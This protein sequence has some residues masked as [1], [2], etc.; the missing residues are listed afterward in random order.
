MLFLRMSKTIASRT[1][2]VKYFMPR[3][4]IAAYA[5]ATKGQKN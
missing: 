2:T 4:Q 3:K 1:H 5:F